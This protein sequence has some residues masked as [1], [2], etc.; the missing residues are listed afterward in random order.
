MVEKEYC[1]ES[2]TE[3]RL[4]TTGEG[5]SEDRLTLA[6]YRLQRSLDHFRDQGWSPSDLSTLVWP[7]LFILTN[8][9]GASLPL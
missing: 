7:L 4:G 3:V 8:A 9:E 1:L 2:G 5:A 6:L